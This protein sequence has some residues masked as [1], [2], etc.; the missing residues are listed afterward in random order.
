M[1]KVYLILMLLAGVFA[2]TQ[3]SAQ[4]SEARFRI[5]QKGGYSNSYW[6]ADQ[7]DSLVFVPENFDVSVSA[8]AKLS[9]NAEWGMSL[10]AWKAFSVD[11]MMVGVVPATYT[12]NDILS[13]Y[14]KKQIT[15]LQLWEDSSAS[16]EFVL[17]DGVYKPVAFGL[18]KTGEKRS[19]YIGEAIDV[20]GTYLTTMLSSLMYINNNYHSCWG[21]GSIMHIRDLMGEEYAMNTT[22]YDHFTAWAFNKNISSEYRYAQEVWVYFDQA[23]EKLSLVV[24]RLNVPMIQT[25]RKAKV[26]LASAMVLRAMHYLD[27]AR[28]YEYLATDGT[29]SVNVHGNDVLNLTYPIGCSTEYAM[30][31]TLVLK[32]ATRQ[33]MRDYIL[34][35]LDEAQYLLENEDVEDKELASL[36]VVYGLKAR[37]YMWTEVY[38]RALE[39]AQK[40]IATGNYDVLT[41][42]EWH[43]PRTGFNNR[44]AKSWMWTMAY[45]ENGQQVTSGIF[46]W[47]SWCSNQ[48]IFGYTGETTN[49]YSLIGASLYE[50]IPNTDFRKRSYKAPKNSPLFGKET[51]L[52]D[53]NPDNIPEL[54]SL[55][56]RPGQGNTT[57]Y[58]V[59]AVVDVPLMRIEEMYFIVCEALAQ[60][61]QTGT[62]VEEL[63]KF[64]KQHR[65][66]SYATEATTSNEVIDEIFFQKR[67]EFWG[68][69]LNFFDYKRLNKPVT[70]NYAGSNFVDN[71]RL[72]TTT[73]PA[74]MNFVF[75]KNAYNGKLEE[76]NNPDPSGC[77]MLY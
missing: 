21:Y 29:S 35:Q 8:K 65:N 33:E 52:S 61:G 17:P 12:E 76:W 28:M 58:T 74:W 60:L 50:K 42:E 46:N 75:V 1:R 36:A 62:A 59:G 3:V 6:S 73:R 31:S 64:M 70:R 25:N 41:K 54:A 2:S 67:I 32:R 55:K 13:A 18:D 19:H 30:D 10:T 71:A 77:Y 72:N 40:A 22:S 56:F 34:A 39:F 47:V 20:S 48:T 27:A 51:Y 26:Y 53:V 16:V 5:Y 14:D 63:T 4:Y 43:N 9:D 15:Y 45:K 44:Q 11:R 38:D 68:E 37:L 57:E 69:G 66:P 23:I 24:D 49:L 7:L